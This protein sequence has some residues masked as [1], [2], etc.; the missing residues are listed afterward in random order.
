[1][2]RTILLG[3]LLPLVIVGALGYWG[4]RR[5]TSKPPKP[6][7]LAVVDRGDVEIK[8]VETGAIEP[9]KKVEVKSKVAGRLARLYVDEGDRVVSGQVLAEIDPTEINSQVA[10][11]Q[12]QVDG[13]RARLAQALTNV[14]YQKEQTDSA[15]RQAEEAVASA[16]ARLRSA[17]A[18]ARTQ[19][20]IVASDVQQAEANLESARKTLELLRSTTHPQQIVQARVSVDEALAAHAQ[21][22]R[23]LE[24]QRSLLAKGFASQQAVDAAV[25]EEAATASR[26]A[27]A[28][29][30][31]ELLAEQHK[32]ELEDAEARVRQ[33]QAALDRARTGERLLS[34]REEDVR[35]A[36]A[37]LEQARAQLLS[38]KSGRKQDRMR[39]DDVAQARSAVQQVENQ[40]REVLVRQHDTRLVATM[41]GVVTKRYVEQGELITS[42]VSTF[43]SG[44]PVLQIAD[45]SRMLIKASI[46]EVDVHKVRVGLP[47]EVTID[48]AK[49]IL[50]RGHVRKVSP[51]ALGSETPSPLQRGEGAVIRFAVEIEIDRPDPVLRPGMSARSTIVVQR[52]RNV[53]RLPAHAVEGDG[54]N[55][56]VQVPVQTTKDGKTVTRY[57]KRRIVAGLRGDT[58]IEIVSGLKQGDK[59]KAGVF[60]GPARKAIELE[61]GGEA[62]AE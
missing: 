8:V 12:A 5:L 51:A 25:A 50:F 23:N 4:Y 47:V 52:R 61:F 16:E 49:G 44:T 2:K 1:M 62:R 42:G 34:T 40:L 56:T 41:S 30:R 29:K 27:Q 33:A 28:Q 32:M 36:R 53:L 18:Q 14:K 46:N 37:A 13:A 15:I 17:E 58:F 6:D 21:A 48:G 3:C 19:P 38:A 7:R 45:L 39:E 11:I 57:E 20:D 55:A 9:L 31:L 26:L 35:A 24:R 22:K 10:Q 60:K 54:R 43:S 59:V